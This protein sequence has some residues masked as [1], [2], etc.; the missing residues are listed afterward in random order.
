M[1]DVTKLPPSLNGPLRVTYERI[2]EGE[3][4][5]LRELG[6]NTPPPQ[7]PLAVGFY[8]ARSAARRPVRAR[9]IVRTF[10]LWVYSRTPAGVRG[11]SLKLL[12][13]PWSAAV[14]H[15]NYRTYD[16]TPELP[17]STCRVTGAGRQPDIRSGLKASAWQ[18]NKPTENDDQL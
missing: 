4:R 5:R 6:K 14:T 16:R 12:L 15:A 1:N 7:L 13:L 17:R 3:T 8:A 2:A 10:S 9:R 11:E 18:G